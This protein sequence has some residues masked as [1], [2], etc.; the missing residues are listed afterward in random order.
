VILPV[1]LQD[2]PA[3]LHE[4]V[5]VPDLIIAAIL[6]VD[7]Y[8]NIHFGWTSK[9]TQFLYCHEKSITSF[10]VVRPVVDA[11][12][13]AKSKLCAMMAVTDPAIDVVEEC[14]VPKFRKSP[15]LEFPELVLAFLTSLVHQYKLLFNT[16]PGAATMAT[17][18]HIPTTGSPVRILPRRILV[19]K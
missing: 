7:F 19:H 9:L 6:D 12:I 17:F 1:S 5:I 13:K 8:N 15:S 3:V 11:D 18:H 2:N 10:S 16:T 4:F 14:M